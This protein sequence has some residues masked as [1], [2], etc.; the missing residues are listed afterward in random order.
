[1]PLMLDTYIGENCLIRICAF[2][3]PGVKIGDR[4]TLVPEQ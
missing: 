2:I 1:M 4:V 3:M